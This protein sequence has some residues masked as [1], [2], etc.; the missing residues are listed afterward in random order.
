MIRIDPEFRSLIPP[1]T[2]EEYTALETSLNNE[3]CRDAL[4]TWK[5]IL[6]DGHN[7]YEICE[8]RGI[9]YRA[10]EIELAERLDA[11]LWIRLNQAARRNLSDDQRA[12]NAVGIME[13]ESEKAMRERA[14]AGRAVGGTASP[15]QLR[16]RLEATAVSKREPKTPKERTRKA[17]A[18]AAGVSE[19]K[20]RA[21]KKLKGK[22]PALAE[23]VALGTLTQKHAD[24]EQRRLDQIA[25]EAA[26]VAQQPETPDT[27]WALTGDEAVIKCDALITDPPYGILTEIWEPKD[28]GA[29]TRG[30]ASRWATSGA[31]TV[32]IFWSQRY[33]F[34][35]REWFDEALTGYKFQQLLVWHYANNMKPQN[36]M[37]FRITWDPIFLYRRMASS[38]QIEPGASKWGAG[39]NDFDCHVAAV[40][41][42]NFSDAECKVHPAQKP[43]SVMRWLINATTNPGELVADPFAGSGTTGIAASQ[44]GRRF[45]GIETD[46]SMLAVAEKR[47]ICYGRV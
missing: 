38:R 42:T 43:V 41:Q 3:G 11:K 47:I 15:E 23:Q 36:R 13:L 44:L 46:T 26:I 18:K 31:D 16:E 35:G 2:A 40:P 39:L 5:G 33:L 4:V 29:F 34:E 30:W 20:V 9:A 17:T 45:H 1:L 7:R 19:R 22:N 37:G 32:L 12:M 25:R 28:L 27:L 6:L 10:C 24:R 14:K 8:R 21:A